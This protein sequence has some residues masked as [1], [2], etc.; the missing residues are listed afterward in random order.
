MAAMEVRDAVED[1]TDAVV[2]LTGLPSAT[3]REL[4]HD[5]S[6]RVATRGDGPI[7]VVVFD[8]RPG[9]VHVTRLAGETDAM[10]QLLAEPVRFA[11][12]E[13]MAV[14]LVVPAEAAAGEVAVAEG[15]TDVGAGPR[16]DGDRTRR[17][18]LEPT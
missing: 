13:G 10:A 5:R 15:F 6:V 4:L 18:R 7:G 16:F 2:E 11:T 3:A 8:A 1:D 9:A 12:R 17:F 14:E